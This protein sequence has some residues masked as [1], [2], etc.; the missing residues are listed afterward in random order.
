MDAAFFISAQALKSE[1]LALSTLA[2]KMLALSLLVGFH[3]PQIVKVTYYS[4][5]SLTALHIRPAYRVIT[6][7]FLKVPTFVI[8]P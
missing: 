1:P 7:T 6:Y 8:K 4:L 2:Q 5:L 3:R